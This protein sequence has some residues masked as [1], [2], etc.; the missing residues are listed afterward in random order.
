LHKYQQKLLVEK[1]L[2]KCTC[3][4]AN[5]TCKLHCAEKE[6]QVI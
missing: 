3:E 6:D 4:F 5:T 1:A 2:G